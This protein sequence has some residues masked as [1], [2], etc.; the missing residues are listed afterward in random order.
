M[1]AKIRLSIVLLLTLAIGL[2]PAV[3]S[4]SGAHKHRKKVVLNFA[5]V[6]AQ[7]AELDL[8]TPGF[9]VGDRFTFSDNLLRSGRQVGVLGGECIVVRIE[10][11]PVPPGQEPT[12]AMVSCSASVQLARGQ[13]TLQGLVTFSAQSG[14]SV[15]IAI[16]GGTG[17]YRTAHG[18][19]TITEGEDENAPGGLR[20]KIIR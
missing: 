9:G 18:V 11:N 1:Q 10:P 8:G 15:K 20:L 17:A 3:S 16:T 4:A 6:T 2:V 5:T 19:A 12:S 7:E 13:I 14:P